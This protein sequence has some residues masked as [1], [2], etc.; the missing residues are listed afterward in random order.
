MTRRRT[1]QPG[2][3][4]VTPYGDHRVVL[5]DD[6]LALFWRGTPHYW[7]TPPGGDYEGAELFAGDDLVTSDE[8]AAD[9]AQP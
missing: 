4:V 2:Q 7:V 9:E 5:G 6:D 3:Y 1:W 8:W